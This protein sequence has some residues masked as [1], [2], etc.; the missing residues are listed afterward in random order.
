[1]YGAKSVVAQTVSRA[2]AATT[3]SGNVFMA[4]TMTEFHT[5]RDTEFVPDS[6]YSTA[7]PRARFCIAE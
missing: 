2:T 3:S 1:M 4:A 7:L 5:S 6:L